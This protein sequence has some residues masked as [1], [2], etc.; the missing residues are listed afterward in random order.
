MAKYDLTL[1]NPFTNAA[2]SL[3]FAPDLRTAFAFDHLGA[4]ITNPI[5]LE[6]RTPAHARAC[7]LY[8]GGFLLHTGYPNPGFR[9][10][11][12]LYRQRW[13]RSPVPIIAHIIGKNMGGLQRMSGE[14]EGL[15]GVL[16]IELGL[17]PDASRE[18]TYQ[19]TQAAL[20]ELP[21]IVRLP[22][23]R[24]VELADI[25]AELGAAS[26]SLGPPRGQLPIAGGQTV[27]GRLYGP[28]IFPQA[29]QVVQILGREGIPVIGAGGV[30]H[31][32]E[33][34]AMLAAGA[35]AVQFDA[36]LWRDGR[37]PLLAGL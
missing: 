9:A 2:G 14:L 31:H 28:A 18:M 37:L 7:L 15:D 36:V 20:G 4:F 29:F 13:A 24:A 23:D 21:L 3:G 33:A 12:R 6:A 1:R 27:S 11:L 22:L 25:P 26:I 34:K 32:E 5:S 19:L 17:P 30:Y 16:G 35:T 10:A 8:S